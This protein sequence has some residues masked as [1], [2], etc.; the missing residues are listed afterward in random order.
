MRPHGSLGFKT[1]TPCGR[2]AGRRWVVASTL[3][4]LVSTHPPKI[5]IPLLEGIIGAAVIVGGVIVARLLASTGSS[6]ILKA[7]DVEGPSKSFDI[8][9][10]GTGS[11]TISC[12]QSTD[13]GKSGQGIMLFYDK[14]AIATKCRPEDKPG[15]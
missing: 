4:P 8:E 2:E 5:A 13:I 7:G 9:V 6:T 15:C 12:S 14:I 1:S 11:D 3:T 10:P